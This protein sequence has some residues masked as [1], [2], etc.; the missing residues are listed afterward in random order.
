MTDVLKQW[1]GQI[2]EAHPELFSTIPSQ[3]TVLKPGQLTEQQV[4]KYFDEVS[5]ACCRTFAFSQKTS[6]ALST[7]ANFCLLIF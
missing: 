6:I 4:K 2:D 5:F 3:P 7:D 1:P